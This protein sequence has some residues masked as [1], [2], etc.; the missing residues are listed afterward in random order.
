[1]SAQ[2]FTLF[3]KYDSYMFRHITVI[4]RPSSL[5]LQLIISSISFDTHTVNYFK[6][7]F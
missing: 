3:I 2:Y 5:L 4:F 1:M 7:Y 6:R